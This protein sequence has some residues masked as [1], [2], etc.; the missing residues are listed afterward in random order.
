MKRTF[1]NASHTKLVLVI[2]ALLICSRAQAQ[3]D[4][5]GA[6]HLAAKL[7]LSLPKAAKVRRAMTYRRATL[8]SVMSNRTVSTARKTYLLNVISMARKRRVDSLL[9][10]AERDRFYLLRDSLI[11]RQ[12][13]ADSLVLR[14]HKEEMN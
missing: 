1:F 7:G 13:V 6:P 10:P 2:F 3:T 5:L 11:A 4:T 8:D 9:T 12:R 14:K